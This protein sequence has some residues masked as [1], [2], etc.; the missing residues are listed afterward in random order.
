MKYSISKLQALRA[1][2]AQSGHQPDD[3]EDASLKA[4]IGLG[5]PGQKYANTRHNLGFM[6]IDEL[7]RQLQAGTPRDRFK[8]QIWET[9]ANEQRLA[10]VKPQTYMNLSGVSVQQVKNWYKL[11]NDEMLVIYDDVDLEFGSLRLKMDGSAGGHNGLSSII[12]SLGAGDVPRL[13]IG[14][15]R[16]RAAT[17]SHVLAG[18]SG[19]DA[20]QLAGTIQSAA[21]AAMLWRREGPVTAMNLVNQ[22]PRPSKPPNVQQEDPRAVSPDI[23]ENQE[24]A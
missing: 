8:A 14:I 6:V 10:L 21:S 11:R 9:L 2:F 18:F 20:D 22:R 17:T 5:N 13:R 3:P 16:G 4:I 12:Q 1:L 19:S 23:K 7:V 24:P 15:G